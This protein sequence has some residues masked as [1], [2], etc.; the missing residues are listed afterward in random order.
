MGLDDIFGATA[1]AV[2]LFLSNYWPLFSKQTANFPSLVP[3]GVIYSSPRWSQFWP[4]SSFCRWLNWLNQ[5]SE[6]SPQ[7]MPSISMRGPKRLRPEEARLERAPVAWAADL[8]F[9][10]F[11]FRFVEVVDPSVS[12]QIQGWFVA[13]FGRSWKERKVGR[14]K[15][16][17]GALAPVWPG[18]PYGNDMTWY[19]QLPKWLVKY[20]KRSQLV[21]GT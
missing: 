9:F 1:D 6:A 16:R 12:K 13:T 3:G 14:R 8:M 19:Y 7:D 4:N 20:I 10:G 5:Q 15:P 11:V 21:N 17:Q 18:K 2:G